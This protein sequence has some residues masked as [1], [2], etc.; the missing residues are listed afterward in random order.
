MRGLFA[1]AASP[2][3]P[4]R[5]NLIRICSSESIPAAGK[6]PDGNY[7]LSGNPFGKGKS[8]ANLDLRLSRLSVWFL[9]ESVASQKQGPGKAGD[10][11]QDCGCEIEPGPVSEKR[12]KEEEVIISKSFNEGVFVFRAPNPKH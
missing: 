4:R 2:K 9:R 1:S 6:N 5:F 7:H 8:G 10:D 3:H 12:R 11:D